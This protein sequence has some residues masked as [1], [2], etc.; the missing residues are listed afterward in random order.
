MLAKSLFPV[1]LESPYAECGR[2]TSDGLAPM[3][4][5]KKI[6]AVYLEKHGPNIMF[7][8]DADPSLVL[9]FITKKNFDLSQT[10]V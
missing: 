9:D 2:N 7:S 1:I 3:T 5:D 10:T 8:R 4:E 6:W